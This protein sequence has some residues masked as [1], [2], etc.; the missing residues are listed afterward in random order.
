MTFFVHSISE[1]LLFFFSNFILEGL[2]I[3]CSSAHITG[4]DKKPICSAALRA[5]PNLLIPIVEKGIKKSGQ[6]L[7]EIDP[8]V[9]WEVLSD[10]TNWTLEHSH[11]R[12]CEDS[13]DENGHCDVTRHPDNCRQRI[14]NDPHR[15]LQRETRMKVS[16]SGETHIER[17]ASRIVNDALST[18]PE[19]VDERHQLVANAPELRGIKKNNEKR[20]VNYIRGQTNLLPGT[21]IP[22][23]LERMTVDYPMTVA[24]NQ[25]IQRKEAKFIHIER[26]MIFFFLDDDLRLIHDARVFVDGTF[27]VAAY[28]KGYY[29]LITIAIKYES[30]DKEKTFCYPVVRV[31]VKDQRQETYEALLAN[32]KRHFQAMYDTELQLDKVH[33]DQEIAM[34]NALK[35]HFPSVQ[36]LLCSLHRTR[37]IRGKAR[38]FLGRYWLSIPNLRALWWS[39]IKSIS[40]VDWIANPELIPVFEDYVKSIEHWAP[41]DKKA[42]AKE[43]AKYVMKQFRSRYFGYENMNHVPDIIAGFFDTTNNVSESLNKHLNTL[44][45]EAR[46]PIN[47]VF[48]IVHNQQKRLLGRRTLVEQDPVNMNPRARET[49]ERREIIT[50]KV[51]DFHAL[52]T[53]D[54]KNGLVHFLMSLQEVPE[55]NDS[56]WGSIGDLNDVRNLGDIE[57]GNELPDENQEDVAVPDQSDASDEFHDAEEN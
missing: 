45:P 33:M 56:D 52:S 17:T 49:I 35:K 2:R 48:G 19:M 24:G 47:R 6:K 39:G 5:T 28:A 34:L 26:D 10:P 31:L 16:R 15:N 4:E 20:A 55:E 32:L 38:E 3:K 21:Q 27:R 11:R 53:D 22:E 41:A 37:A 7:Y 36:I 12:T 51:R 14:R 44:I 30:P 43:V 46:Q 1:V 25:V 42:A 40:F 23:R 54:K 9:S 18:I 13:V 57:E 8:D 29:Q 50:R